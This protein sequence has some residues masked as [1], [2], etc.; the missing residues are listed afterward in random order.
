M[1]TYQHR[2]DAAS[3]PGVVALAPRISASDKHNSDAAYLPEALVGAYTAD[4]GRLCPG[5]M[6]GRQRSSGTADRATCPF[7]RYDATQDRSERFCRS[8]AEQ[9]P[10]RCCDAAM[11]G[12]S[13]ARN[14]PHMCAV[15]AA[16][17]GVL[18]GRHTTRYPSL[19]GLA[20]RRRA[21]PCDDRHPPE[22]RT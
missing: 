5:L 4:G 1:D 14:P 18:L 20:C 16:P 15:H 10:T 8:P 12:V 17:R 7:T 19:V 21:S 9:Q 2:R 22:R 11:I 3:G 13:C 6:T